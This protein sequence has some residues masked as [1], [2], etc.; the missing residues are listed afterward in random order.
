MLLGKRLKNLYGL[1][2]FLIPYFGGFLNLINSCF[3]GSPLD[4]LQLLEILY[5]NS[6]MTVNLLITFIAIEQLV[7]V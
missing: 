4:R 2:P 5:L 1:L 3:D 6:T 7:F